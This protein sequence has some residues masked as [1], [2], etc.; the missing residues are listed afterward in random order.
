[1]A[2]EENNK[3]QGDRGRYSENV[4]KERMKKSKNVINPY[5]D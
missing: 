2:D 3:E 4:R 5:M 1:M